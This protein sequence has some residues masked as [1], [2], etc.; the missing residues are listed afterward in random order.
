MPDNV[1]I[2]IDTWEIVDYED[3]HPKAD[4]APSPSPVWGDLDRVW[5]D[6]RYY[7]KPSGLIWEVEEEGVTHQLCPRNKHGTY[8]Y[9]IRGQNWG[10][11]SQL[12][13]VEALW[14]TL[15]FAPELIDFV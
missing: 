7:S 1:V 13:E 3:E 8:P 9:R 10:R 12:S 4:Q 2:D 15:E 14:K 11:T 5:L 6:G